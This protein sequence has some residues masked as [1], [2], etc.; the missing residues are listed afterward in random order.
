M[1]RWFFD[2]QVD[3]AADTKS[4]NTLHTGCILSI[5]DPEDFPDACSPMKITASIFRTDSADQ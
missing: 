4:Q 1:N 3:H 5:A 2:R